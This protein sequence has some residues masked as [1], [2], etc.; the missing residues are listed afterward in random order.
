LLDIY[1][2]SLF[3]GRFPMFTA[4]AAAS[5]RACGATFAVRFPARNP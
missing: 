5:I 2:F 4:P 1:A 3:R